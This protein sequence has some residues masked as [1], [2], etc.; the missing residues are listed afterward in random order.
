ME[1]AWRH[2]LAR[3]KASS[4]I[5]DWRNVF[6]STEVELSCFHVPG[7]GGNLVAVQASRISTYLHMNGIPMG[8]P[9]PAPRKCPTPCTSFF[10]SSKLS[11][12]SGI[13]V[14][15]SPSTL[16]LIQT[17][18]F[19][20]EGVLQVRLLAIL[21]LKCFLCDKSHSFLHYADNVTWVGAGYT[22]S[23]V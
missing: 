8:D 11:G 10:G 17:V 1:L 15:L 18:F 9:N 14:P 7:V 13:N 22:Q 6:V 16:Y 19:H 23:L 20:T 5:L 4:T 3:L 21:S 12:S 2:A